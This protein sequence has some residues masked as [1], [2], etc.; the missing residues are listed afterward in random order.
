MSVSGLGVH[1]GMVLFGSEMKDFTTRYI[2]ASGWVCFLSLG[3]RVGHP[4]IVRFDSEERVCS[5][6]CSG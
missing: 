3:L 6:R 4:R 2:K 5:L 1:P